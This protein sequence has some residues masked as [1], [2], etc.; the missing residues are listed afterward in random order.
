MLGLVVEWASGARLTVLLEAGYCWPLVREA[1]QTA[2]PW[3]VP[4]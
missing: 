1:E 4:S 3:L 2:G